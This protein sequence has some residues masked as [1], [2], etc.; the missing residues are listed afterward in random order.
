MKALSMAL[1]LMGS[2]AFAGSGDVRSAAAGLKNM[3][4][5]QIVKTDAGDA[6]AC[7]SEMSADDL[8]SLRF[9]NRRAGIVKTLAF[10][11]T[12]R[13]Q[14]RRAK[15]LELKGTAG[16]LTVF[17]SC[18]TAPKLALYVDINCFDS[19]SGK[20]VIRVPIAKE[21]VQEQHMG[22]PTLQ[23]E[24]R[25]QEICAQSGSEYRGMWGVSLM[26]E[27]VTGK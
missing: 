24:A 19:K 17:L 12:V 25:F 15:A 9:L 2:T 16:P 14:N 26:D 11:E 27:E 6:Y 20:N 7:A 8:S 1:V 13:V 4:P 3:F 5:G 22:L 10:G 18:G 21:E 23:A